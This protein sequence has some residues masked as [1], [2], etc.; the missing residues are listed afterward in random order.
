MRP[1]IEPTIS[2]LLWLTTLA[3]A[4]TGILGVPAIGKITP[5]AREARTVYLVERARLKLA[6]EKGATIT[7]RGRAT[8]TYRAPIVA[9]FT[10]KPKSVTAH[11]TIYP[12]GGS[13]TGSANANYKVIGNLGYFG[14]TFTLG[15]GTGKYVHVTEVN[16]KPLGVSGVINRS[17]FEAEVKANGQAAGF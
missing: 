11:V 3:L 4:V 8:G 7:E 16:H 14:G 13:I 1:R 15:R 12:A 10:I 9:L 6:T 17:N 2:Q 5:A